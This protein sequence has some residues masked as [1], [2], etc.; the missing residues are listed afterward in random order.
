MI[1]KY[2]LLAALPFL[3]SATLGVDVSQRTYQSAFSCFKSNNYIF[4]L[5][6]VYQSSGR[7]DPNGPANINDAWN[8]GMRNV[9]GYIFPCYSCGNPEQQMKDTVSYLKSH[10]LHLAVEGEDT[11]NPGNLTANVGATVGMLW[12]DVEGT[13]YWSTSSSNNINFLQRMV[14]EGKRQGVNL[15]IY[16][17]K[18]QWDPIMGGSSKFNYLPLWYAHYDNWASFGD[19]VSFG[20]WS[21]PAIKQYAGDVGLC[22]VNVDKNYY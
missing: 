2:L 12:L 11:S 18:Y 8:G 19:F 7:P 21:K 20:G 14:D 15:G 22:G 17:S 5:I 1:F 13:Q 4:A 16:S 6:R 3:A 10:N 9:D